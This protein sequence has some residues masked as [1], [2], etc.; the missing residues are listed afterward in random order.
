MKTKA[1][2][3][4]VVLSISLFTGC[5]QQAP[6]P[7]PAPQTPAAPD[8]SK[9]TPN[10]T[11]DTVTTASIVNNADAFQ[12]AIA[13]ENGTWIIALTNDLTINKDLLLEGEYKNGK[14]DANGKDIIQRK[15]A[16]YAQDANRNVTARYTL[17]APKLTVTS[18]KARIQGGTFKG[19]LYVASKD[20]ELVDATVDGNVYFTTDEAKTTFKMDK[21]KITGKQELKKS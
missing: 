8:N 12:K 6:A 9:S 10:A 4:L 11:P 2:L 18:P 15:I 3:L 20:F 1:I 19:D 17:T 13:K 5:T 7:A 14:K 16:L 21:A